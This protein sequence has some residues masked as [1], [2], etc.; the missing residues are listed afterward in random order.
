MPLNRPSR[1]A[2]LAGVGTFAGASA[3]AGK[4]A[5]LVR[6]P[7]AS[8]G[9]FYPRQRMRMADVDND[10]VKVEGAVREA[11]GEIFTLKG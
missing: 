4:A 7:Y 10:L 1:R 2:L 11:G 6:T 3:L 9:P 5:A 8:E